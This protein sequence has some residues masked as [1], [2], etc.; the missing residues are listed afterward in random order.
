[1]VTHMTLKY[2]ASSPY[3]FRENNFLF[4]YFIMGSMGKK[5]TSKFNL[6]PAPDELKLDIFYIT[7][8]YNKDVFGKVSAWR[9]KDKFWKKNVKVKQ[10]FYIVKLCNRK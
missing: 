3:S 9:K 7:Y 2:E 6:T 4:N 8:I 10:Y 5:L 1:M